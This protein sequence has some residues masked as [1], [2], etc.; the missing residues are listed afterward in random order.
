MRV[1]GT[2]GDFLGDQE[3]EEVAMAQ[4]LGLAAGFEFGV[5]PAYG[6]QMQAPEHAI[7][8]ERG[9]HC[10]SCGKSSSTWCAA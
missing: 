3:S 5:E 1:L 9:H 10:T 7:E 2:M 4:A 8:I 6:R